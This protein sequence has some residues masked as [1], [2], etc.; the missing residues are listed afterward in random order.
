M[1]PLALAIEITA[2]A[3]TAQRN[4]MALDVPEEARRLARKYPRAARSEAEVATAL[5]EEALAVGAVVRG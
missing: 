3:L 2:L 4:D 1:E 5:K